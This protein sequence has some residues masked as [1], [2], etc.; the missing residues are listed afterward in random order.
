MLRNNNYFNTSNNPKNKIDDLNKI[1]YDISTTSNIIKEYKKL[2]KR[3]FLNSDVQL[4]QI[5]SL[6]NRNKTISKE[7]ESLTSGFFPNNKKY[8]KKL[9]SNIYNNYIKKINEDDND[10]IQPNNQRNI[11]AKTNNNFYNDDTDHSS[12]ET[13]KKILYSTDSKKEVKKDS[14]NNLIKSSQINNM[15]NLKGIF[16][17]YKIIKEKDDNNSPL[18]LHKNNNNNN[19]NNY[20]YKKNSKL[21]NDNKT[22]DKN[23]LNKINKEL[24]INAKRV[25]LKSMKFIKTNNNYDYDFENN[26]SIN[27]SDELKDIIEEKEINKHKNNNIYNNNNNNYTVRKIHNNINININNN[28]GDNNNLESNNNYTTRYNNIDI[29]SNFLNFSDENDHNNNNIEKNNDIFY[30]KE[31]I[32][33]LTEEINNKNILINEYSNLA[34]KSKIKFEQLIIHN[35]KNMEKMQKENKKQIILYKSK[36]INI[37]KEKQNIFNKYMENKQYTEFLENLLFNQN[38]SEKNDNNNNNNDENKKIKNLEK[39]IKK[40][41]SEISVIKLELETKNKD[42]EKL[43]NIIIKYKE[44]KNYRAISNPRKNVNIIEQLKEA[45]STSKNNNKMKN[46]ELSSNLEPKTKK[47]FNKNINLNL[48]EIENE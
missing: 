39:I 25:A 37:E 8:K 44:N 24:S 11:Q 47:Y 42:N 21:D 3:K 26:N 9:H 4:N 28:K 40:L 23:L 33:E 22:I 15:P 13:I 17:N 12:M 6:Y 1:K 48:K 5:N 16:N 46:K 7:K 36:I 18:T 20:T 19:I 2:S 29:D 41:M 43:K 34:K 27:I 14:I 31:K 32:K 38:N 10:N 30:L 45:R 35:K